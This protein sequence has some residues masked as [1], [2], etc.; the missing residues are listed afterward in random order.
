MR[1]AEAGPISAALRRSTRWPLPMPP[2]MAYQTVKRCHTL[3]GAVRK[4][5]QQASLFVPPLPYLLALRQGGAVRQAAAA[6]GEAERQEGGEPHI[7]SVHH[8]SA[9][10]ARTAATPTN[11]CLHCELP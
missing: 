5:H 10:H 6:G 2:V 4:G 1:V 3:P 8:H 11:L 7:G 9:A